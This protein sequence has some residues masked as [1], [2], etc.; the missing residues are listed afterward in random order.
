MEPKAPKKKEKKSNVL[1]VLILEDSAADAALM[2]H[3][4]KKSGIVFVSQRVES[5]SEFLKA[6]KVFKADLIL[7]DFKLPRFDALQALALRNKITPAIPLI[8]VTGSVS[9]EIAVDCMKQGADDYLLKDRMTRLGE[10]V[11]RALAR[12]RLQAEKIAAGEALH[13]AAAQWRATFDAMNDAVCLLDGKGAVLRCNRAMNRLLGLPY[14]E[15]IGKD[16]LGLICGKKKKKSCSFQLMMRSRQRMEEETFWHGRHY[17]VTVDPIIDAGGKVAGAVHIMSDV[18]DAME[19]AEKLSASEKQFHDLYENATIGLYRTKPDGRIVMANC[20]LVRML[21]Y[22][23]FAELAGRDLEQAGF[24]PDYPRRD[25]RDRIER[26]GQVIGLESGWKR[27]D[28]KTIFVRESAMPIRAEDGSIHFYDGTVEDITER[29]RAEEERGKSESLLQTILNN[30]PI[31]IFVIDDRGVFTFSEGKGLKKTGLKPSENVGVPALELYHSIPFVEYSGEVITGKEVIRRV[32]A[33][34]TI[35][36]VDELHGVYFDNHVIPIRNSHGKVV[37]IVGVATD[38]TER[39][40]S[41]EKLRVTSKR[42]ELALAAAQAGTWDWNVATGLIE[43]SPQMF[44]LFGLDPRSSKASFASWRTALHPE[45]REL[46]GDRIDQALKQH[47]TLDSDYRIILPG[48]QIRW[49]NAMGVGVY[50]HAGRPTQMIGICQDISGRKHTEEQIRASLLEKEVLLKEIHHRV[51]NNLQVISGLLSLQAAQTND[52]QLQRLVKSSQDRIWTMALIHQTLYQSGNLAD[53]D[54]A[55]YIRSLVGNLLSAHAQVA[56]PP[57]VRFDLAAIHLTI[58]K[59]IPLALIIN[60]LVTNSM[61]H[62]FAD[63][64]SGDIRI[65]LHE[66]RG[67][68]FYV[69]TDENHAPTYELI[70]ADNGVGLPA[71]FDLKNQKSLGLQLVT[72]LIKQLDGQV[73]IESKDG[74]TVRIRF[75]TNEKTKNQS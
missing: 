47:G 3:E 32:M 45:D 70:I 25:F 22:K 41:E 16:C 51:K 20:A 37:G 43:W 15:V 67:V 13:A 71:G 7:A 17:Q 65:S 6:L 75:N 64:R 62:A 72:M 29:K 19:A 52:E 39:R 10:A 48:G 31:T 36:A 38:I 66:C 5:K 2:E 18:T 28:G 14:D 44:K 42:L 58:D 8:V 12:R 11:G 49:I 26:D 61:K 54:M 56:M 9:E 46:A 69:P 4:L 73:A 60:E 23:S 63:G 1:R 27:R 55:D 40:Q 24:E 53:I 50:D 74:T 68:K 57:S 35:N 34:E 33:G 30:A 59:A 21:G